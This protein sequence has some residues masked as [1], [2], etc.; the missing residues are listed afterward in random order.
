MSFLF[1]WLGS[2]KAPS[3]SLSQQQDSAYQELVVQLQNEAMPITWQEMGAVEKLQGA[4]LP[5]LEEF[6][7]ENPG[8]TEQDYRDF[9]D[10]YWTSDH[11][12]SHFA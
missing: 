8:T 4:T 7:Q 11:Q 1:R 6:Q 3:Q 2:S 10:G 5:T 9:S 12:S